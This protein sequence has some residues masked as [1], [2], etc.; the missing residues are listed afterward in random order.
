MHQ[1]SK[2][3]KQLEGNYQLDFCTSKTCC[4]A[5]F[6]VQDVALETLS[7]CI[8]YW[9][10]T[11]LIFFVK[12]LFP[13][14]FFLGGWGVGGGAQFESKQIFQFLRIAVVT[15]EQSSQISK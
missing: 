5:D 11:H 9:R 15:K 12:L 10:N 13:S 6:G 7:A 3:S 4:I 8:W 2:C 1:V 14:P